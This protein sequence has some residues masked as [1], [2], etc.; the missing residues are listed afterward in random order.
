MPPVGFEPTTPASEQPQTYT[1]DH[2]AHQDWPTEQYVTI[3]SNYLTTRSTIVPQKL[4]VPQLIKKFPAFYGTQMFITLFTTARHL[5]RSSD[6]SIQ[7]LPLHP[8][9]L[10]FVLLYSPIYV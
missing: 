8:S 2:T 1:L 5:P 9:F 6:T 7:S 4:A 3:K 10:R